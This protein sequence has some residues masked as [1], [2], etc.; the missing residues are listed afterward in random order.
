MNLVQALDQKI[1]M[2]LLDALSAPGRRLPLPG[3]V[4]QRTRFPAA[5]VLEVLLDIET[6]FSVLGSGASDLTDEIRLA[7]GARPVP[8]PEADFLVVLGPS[9]DGA[10]RS[11]RRGRPENPEEGATVFYL[12]DGRTGVPP[13]G[14]FRLRG[15]G[16]RPDTEQAPEMP[17]LYRD[18]LRLL[19]EVNSDFPLGVDAFFLDRES[20]MA[21]PHSV[22][23]LEGQPKM[24]E[25]PRGIEAPSFPPTQ[26]GGQQL[27]PGERLRAHGLRRRP[28]GPRGH[29]GYVETH[30]CFVKHLRSEGCAGDADVAG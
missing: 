25:M 22:G 16:I 24:V 1:F 13:S 10:L 9:S 19:G 17:G 18:E 14:S 2:T 7:T 23:I 4:Q 20:V 28:G 15:P 21:L 29:C 12:L 3:H 5:R 11:A 30:R 26:W 27:C 6:G 8:V